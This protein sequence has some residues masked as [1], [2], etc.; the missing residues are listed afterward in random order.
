M[1]WLDPGIGFG[2]TTEH[3]LDLIAGLDSLA[4]LGYPVLVGASRKR[5]I[6]DISGDPVHE[7]LA[8]SLVAVHEAMKLPKRIVRVHDV[9]QTRQFIL[10]QQAVRIHRAARL[11]GQA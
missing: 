11:R 7:R 9:A 1:I 3:N 5:F 6:G 10:V 8:G 2:K 4:S